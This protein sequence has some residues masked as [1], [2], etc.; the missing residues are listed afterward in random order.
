MIGSSPTKDRV[1]LSSMSSTEAV[2]NPKFEVG[3][4]RLDVGMTVLEK[5]LSREHLPTGKPLPGPN[6]VAK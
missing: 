6:L 1:V 2:Y 4:S 3:M 5:Q